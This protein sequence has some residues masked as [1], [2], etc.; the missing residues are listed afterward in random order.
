MRGNVHVHALQSYIEA[1]NPA[2]PF[3]SCKT[4][5]FYDITVQ[6]K[7]CPTLLKSFEQFCDAEELT[8]DNQ[9]CMHACA[10]LYACVQR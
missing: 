3:K 7:G 9:V 2:I 4:E 8:G 10:C 1:K 6:V 5:P